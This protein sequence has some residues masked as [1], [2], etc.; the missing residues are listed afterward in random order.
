M[1][2]VIFTPRDY[3]ESGLN[4]I[5][6][7]EEGAMLAFPPGSGKTPV[8]LTVADILMNEDLRCERTLV[9]GPKLVA[10]EVWVRE[11]P[12]WDHLSHLKVGHIPKEVFN[13]KVT[14]TLHKE[15]DV[16]VVESSMAP[17][18]S[19]ATRAAILA[20]P[21]RIMTVSRDHFWWLAK[22]MGNKWPWDLVIWDESTSIKT[23][24][25]K[26]TKAIRYLCKL[27]LVKMFIPLSGTPRP[28]SLEQFW[29]QVRV[30]DG[31]RRLGLM[32]GDKLDTT[33]GAFRERFM[34]P[35]QFEIRG[36]TVIKWADRPGALEEVMAAVSDICLSVRSEVWRKTEPPLTVVREVTLPPAVREMYETLGR[37]KVLRLANGAL[38]TA[39]DPAILAS[40][41]LQLAAG[42]I[43]DDDGQAHWL[44]D[45]KI[46][47]LIELL[48]ELEGEPVL[49]LYWHKAVEKRLK[50]KIKGLA[51]TKTK[52]FLDQ[53][54][55]GL[56]PALALHP[57]SAGHGLD[58]LQ[59]GGHHVAC[60]EI[61]PDWECYQQAVS[62]LDRGGQAFQVTVHQLQ[63]AATRDQDIGRLL[64][65]SE[66]CQERVIEALREKAPGP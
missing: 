11:C 60:V 21:E 19:K 14:K 16:E 20:M 59:N 31:G 39:P 46:D 1:E 58:G 9:V 51:T 12:K 47:A 32:R 37:T 36:R 7:S 63:A 18:D 45:E 5:R 64:E 23:H 50:E 24:D 15:G 35:Q 55:A 42:F 29:S 2:R 53:F 49:I 10:Q 61:F 57:A 4:L 41:R 48:E 38:I 44:H 56:M 26:R 6:Y 33:L 54:A 30:I 65:S 13:Y 25:S 22:V 62:R 43:Y 8:A 34:L 27:G 40:K 17:A 3:Q 28:K 66:A 52:G